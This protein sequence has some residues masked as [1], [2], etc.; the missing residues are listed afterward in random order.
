M[1]IFDTNNETMTKIKQG[2]ENGK[3]INGIRF[4]I[5]KKK[6]PN[7]TV[8]IQYIKQWYSENGYYLSFEYK[9]EKGFY[10]A[11]NKLTRHGI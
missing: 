10:N 6:H 3:T 7:G 1:F 4:F 2:I 5:H 9:N 8:K 11:I